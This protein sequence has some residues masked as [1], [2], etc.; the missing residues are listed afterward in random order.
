MTIKY[1]LVGFDGLR[2]DMITPELMPRLY[3]HSLEGVVFEN[4]RSAFPTE[5]YVNLPSLVT[6][7]TP[8]RHGMIA[9]RYLDPKVDPR[10]PFK[11]YS[12]ARIE[13]AQRAYKGK[14]YGALSLG[15]ILHKAQRRMAVISTNS[16]GST[17]LKHHQILEH[18]HL[19]LA[20]H[21]SETSWPPTEVARILEKLGRPSPIKIPDI[22]GTSYASDVFLEH[23]ALGDLPDLTV[24]WYGEPD[25]SYH[26]FGL[27][28]P[29]NCLALRHVD[30][31][32]GRVLDWWQNSDM[33]ES[34]QI[35]VTS[36]HGHITQRHKANMGAHL[37]QSGFKVAEH[38]EDG[39]DLALLAA[40]SGGIWVRDKNPELI[41][42]IGQAMMDYDACGMIFSAP[43]NEVEGIVPGSFSRHLVMAN[44]PRSPDISYILNTTNEP[45]E[46][47]YTGTCSFESELA[48]GA[49][50]H[51]GLHPKE[52][53]SVCIAAGSQFGDSQTFSS[54]SGII[55]VAPTILH[56]LNI[57]APQ[58]MDGQILS[59]AFC[60]LP[61]ND[62]RPIPEHYETGFGPY[63]QILHRTRQ[64]DTCY[65]DSGSRI[66]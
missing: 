46:Y 40:Y 36:D 38:L 44:H 21:N 60:N 16:G 23:I 59:A 50:I 39:A 52:L 12:V 20:C 6:G 58:G 57:S 10:E 5:T 37:R 4:H 54:H 25:E 29:E 48:V 64:G 8:S 27:G 11:G 47:G 22:E 19:S 53:Q 41:T 17:R 9:N 66:R 63:Q 31:Q 28:S 1:L 15:E 34:L 30:A 3:Q 51:G 13:K 56:G 62:I 35:I 49:G 43:H 2:P 14:L 18:E 7:S 32:F 42:A 33:R 26:S 55:D 45:N 24:L 65:L 61:P